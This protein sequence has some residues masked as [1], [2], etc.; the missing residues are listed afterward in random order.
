MAKY[1]LNPL[2]NCEYRAARTG[3]CIASKDCGYKACFWAGL[4]KETDL[5]LRNM[6]AIQIQNAKILELL[7]K[8]K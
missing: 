5:L 7:Q 4:S 3:E 1:C 6:C 2:I 8:Q